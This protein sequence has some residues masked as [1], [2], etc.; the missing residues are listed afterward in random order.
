VYSED[1]YLNGAGSEVAAGEWP[2]MAEP[3]PESMDEWPVTVEPAVRPESAGEW[4]V[5]PE[6]APEWTMEEAGP[7]DALIG[8]HVY[9][10]FAPVG[11]TDVRERRLRRM[12]GV[13]VLAGAVGAVGGVVAAN[14]SRAH[15]GAGRRPGS[16]VAAMR[17]SRLARSPVLVGSRAAPS[18]PAVARP[19]KAMRSHLARARRHALASA[20]LPA[21]G[22]DTRPSTD[23]HPHKPVR[24][25]NVL[26][27]QS[28][29]VAVQRG[30]GARIVVDDSVGS[31]APASMAADFSPTEATAPAARVADAEFGFE[32]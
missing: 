14:S 13:A 7:G 11:Y 10:G 23:V 19:S 30:G 8:D 29:G 27:P 24:Q 22:S 26:A 31:S 21:R 28:A 6:P 15:R 12:A 4:P 1:E 25:G 2:A 5:E 16:L 18:E 20:R 17:S 9:G 3:T 32:H